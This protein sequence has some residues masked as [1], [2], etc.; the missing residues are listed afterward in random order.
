M[1]Q[2]NDRQSGRHVQGRR[3]YTPSRLENHSGERRQADGQRTTSEGTSTRSRPSRPRKRRTN[4]FG[5][6]LYVV[7]VIGLSALLAALAWVAASDM[8]ALNKPEHVATIT[9]QEGATLDQV[10]NLLEENQLIEH[11]LVFKLFASLTHVERDNKITPGTYELDTDMDYHALI[12]SMGKGS[13]SRKSVKVVITEGM[14]VDQIFQMLEDQGISTVEKLREV[15]ANHPFKYSFLKDL[16]SGD[17]RRLEGY[18]F[19]DTYE[20]YMGGD[21]LQ[22]INKMIL[23]FDE[24]FT[25]ELRQVAAARNYTVGDIV[26][27]ASM[28]EKE[29]DGTDQTK[30]ASVIYNRLEHPSDGGTYGLLNIDAT[31]IYQTGRVPV[32]SADMSDTSNPYNTYQHTGLPPTAISNPGIVAIRAALYPADTGYYYYALGDDGVHHFFKRLKEQQKFIASQE[33]YKTQS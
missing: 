25:E 27:I 22:I 28:I 11:K 16:P 1:S 14:T 5:A 33:R 21:P 26:N 13:A 9:I 15:A 2:E 24:M 7:F 8:L 10:T 31:I 20:F 4:T 30:I 19:P 18:L 23:R 29:T 32:T 12:N 3:K 17:Y 6:G